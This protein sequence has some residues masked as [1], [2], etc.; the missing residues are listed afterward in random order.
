MIKANNSKR[1]FFKKVATAVG[2][3]A[4]ANYAR[5]LM[6][7]Y[8]DSITEVNNHSAN[9]VNMQKKALLKKQLV[10][11]TDN[12]KKQMLNEIL[13]IYDKNHA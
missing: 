10:P 4:A 5:N 8:T 9:D 3:V 11:M 12:E 13:D 2:F 7:A 1:A 6:S